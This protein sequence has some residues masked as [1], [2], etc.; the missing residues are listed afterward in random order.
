MKPKQL[1]L[2]IAEASLELVP[3]SLWG[4]PAVLGAARRRGKRPGETILDATLHHQALRQLPNHTKR[5]R[6]DIVHLLL[7]TAL[8][9]PLNQEGR[10]RVYLHTLADTVV[11]IDPATRLPKNYNRFIGL[12]EQLLTTG[13]VPPGAEKPLLRAEKKTLKQ[14]LDEINPDIIVALTNNAPYHPPTKLAQQLA[15]HNNPAILVPGFPHGDYE[16]QTT[17]LAHQLAKIHPHPLEPH[18][19]LCILLTTLTLADTQP[20]R[21]DKPCPQHHPQP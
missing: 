9:S 3:R 20:A 1:H 17:Q 7:H 12:M 21:G 16:P 13:A 2:I 18:A 15:Q 5:G 11:Y 19:Q 14:L 4:H 6:P 8:A 10:L